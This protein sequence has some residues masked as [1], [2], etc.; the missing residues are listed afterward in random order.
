MKKYWLAIAA[1][2]MTLIGLLRA[3]GGI[4]LIMKGKQLDTGTPIMASETQILLASAGLLIVGFF[5]IYA[6]IN[7]LRKP[8][9]LSWSISWLALILFFI[10]GLLNGYLLFGQPLDQGQKINLI[11]LI[12]AGLFL[13]LGKSSLKTEG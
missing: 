7:L 10:G 1:L 6:G 8:A 5:L 11:A 3:V 13:F 2:I 9:P 12:L 4:A